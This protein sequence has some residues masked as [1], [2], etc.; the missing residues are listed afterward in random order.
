M[1]RSWDYDPT[2]Y[3]GEFAKRALAGEKFEL[4]RMK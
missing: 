4:K 3:W 2:P 1:I